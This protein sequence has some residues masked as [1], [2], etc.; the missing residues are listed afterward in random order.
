MLLIFQ[1]PTLDI[2]VL[3]PASPG[4]GPGPAQAAGLCGRALDPLTSVLGAE[5]EGSPRLR[6]SIIRTGLNPQGSR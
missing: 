6:L 4:A 3:G 5:L 1:T 2:V